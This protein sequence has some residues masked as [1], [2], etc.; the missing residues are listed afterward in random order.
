MRTTLE[1]GAW[2]E[3]VPIGELKGK[4]KRA[5]E[6]AGKPV[7]GGDSISDEGK[8]DVRA[9]VSGMDISSWM[10]AK[11]DA[12]WAVL[13]DA[14]SYDLPVPELEGD[15]IVSADSLGELP[16][17]DYEE[18]ERLFEPYA[19]KLARRPDPKTS[20][21]SSSNGS[22]RASAGHGPRTG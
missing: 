21:T 1:S 15:A 6:R 18:I 17:D 14:W 20:T 4:H 2:I 5:L 7:L 11:Q 22:S 3:H 10:A 9:L 16:L 8:V 19:A 12:L 13:I